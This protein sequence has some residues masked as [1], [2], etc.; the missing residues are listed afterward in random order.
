MIGTSREASSSS[1]PEIVSS[2]RLRPRSCSER[3]HAHQVQVAAPSRHRHDAMQ[4]A[5][6]LEAVIGHVLVLERNEGKARKDRVAVVAVVVDRV[7]A[8]DRLPLFP[9][10]NSCC[11]STG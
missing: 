2:W 9:A 11:G 7:A 3:L 5:A 8:V 4:Q 1:R 6:P 10:R